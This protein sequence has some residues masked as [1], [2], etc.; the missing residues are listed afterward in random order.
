MITKY[1][2]LIRMLSN[3]KIMRED[4]KPVEIIDNLFIGSIGSASNLQNLKEA[5]ITHIVNA[6]RGIKRYFPDDFVYVNY[7]LLDSP[8]ENIKKHFEESGAFIDEALKNNG[9]VFVHW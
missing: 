2:A 6:A 3:M 8:D 5:G 9:K 4:A 1:I 7:D